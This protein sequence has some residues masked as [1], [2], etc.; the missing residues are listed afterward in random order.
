MLERKKHI[1]LQ[2]DLTPVKEIKFTSRAKFITVVILVGLVII[3]FLN[4]WE[5]LPPFIWAGVTAFIFNGPLK[6]LCAR[7]GGPRWAWAAGIYVVF[8]AILA[9]AIVLIVPAISKEAKTLATDSPNIRATVDNYL[10]NNP[11]VSVA[12]I[13]IQSDTVRNALNNVLDRLPTL[14][15]DL[16]PG[17]VS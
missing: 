11:T 10:T 9:L 4:V 5:A 16:G 3:Y 1:I 17:L 12:G 8:L 2:Q 14:A 15:Q 13:E 6:A 7:F